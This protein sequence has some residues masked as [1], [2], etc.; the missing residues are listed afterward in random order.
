MDCTSPQEDADCRSCGLLTSFA[1]GS[2]QPCDC[3]IGF[4][5]DTSN[6]GA[7]TNSCALD[8]TIPCIGLLGRCN[9]CRED[10]GNWF[11]DCVSCGLG[12]FRQYD[13]ATCLD[14]CPTGSIGLPL[15]NE[16]EAI[17]LGHI[18]SAFFNLL[19]PIYKGLPFGWYR[20]TSDSL[21]DL[22]PFNT[23][24]RGIWFDGDSGHLKITGIVLNTNF[25]IH[26]WVYFMSF[27]GT[28]LE[29]ESE[30]PTTADA[31][32]TLSYTCGESAS[33]ANEADIGCGYNKEETTSSTSGSDLELNK[34]VDLNIVAKWFD[35]SKTMDIK[36]YIG[37][38]ELDFSMNG[39]PFHH[40]NNSDI[41]FCKNCNAFVL[42][43]KIFNQNLPKIEVDG[44][45]WNLDFDFDFNLDVCAIG[46]FL[47]GGSCTPCVDGC[48]V[49]E[50]SADN[51]QTGCYDVEC[52]S[53]DNSS[54]DS[55][56]HDCSGN[57]LA[58]LLNGVCECLSGY[59]RDGPLGLC[60][61]GGVICSVGAAVGRCDR[62]QSN[63]GPWWGDCLSCQGNFFLQPF[64]RT[65][66]DYCP[67][68]SI[69]LLN[70]CGGFDVPL[71]FKTAF[72][73]L[74]P[75]ISGFGGIT[76]PELNPPTLSLDRGFFFN[77]VNNLFNLTG[78]VINSSFTVMTWL[79]YTKEAALGINPI[80]SLDSPIPEGTPGAF[81]VFFETSPGLLGLGLNLDLKI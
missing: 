23:I 33:N 52:S 44:L 27:K 46:S 54:Q 19:G 21:F 22:R 63:N 66:A 37:E 30:T 35:A 55:P 71:V 40:K 18:S 57:G 8:I 4:S 80:F 20:L 69:G 75:D 49:C 25:S 68:G 47:F 17:G 26:N 48:D 29:V 43:F 38:F 28:L 39:N 7:K 73:K 62:C 16:C 13:V 32:Q 60:G 72:D 5:R 50:G 14:Y 64:S 61:V 79:K 42:N 36:F 41:I 74:I 70:R 76:L 11:G 6:G 56:C 81:N 31:D 77:G 53:C 34:W 24:T 3:K 78:L 10:T 9:D 59:E 15:L 65:C 2:S 67:S 58:S 12:F 45:R 51:C 1:R